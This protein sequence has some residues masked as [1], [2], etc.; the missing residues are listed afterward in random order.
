MVCSAPGH[1]ALPNAKRGSSLPASL[2][3][4]RCFPVVFPRTPCRPSHGFFFDGRTDALEMAPG[5]GDSSG[6][7]A[8]FSTERSI[9]R[10]IPTCNQTSLL[11][12]PRGFCRPRTGSCF[13]ARAEGQTA[14][15]AAWLPFLGR[16]AP[17]PR[18]FMSF[19]EPPPGSLDQA[20][21]AGRRKRD[22]PEHEVR[23]HLRGAPDPH[24]APA[25]VVLEV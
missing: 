18:A 15:S 10:L 25:A 14:A 17:R 23:H 3:G 9:R 2:A 6:N 8:P 4:S 21:Q 22:H 11:Q 1:G 12:N 19:S 7:N 20:H 16:A 5:L 24:G 13:S